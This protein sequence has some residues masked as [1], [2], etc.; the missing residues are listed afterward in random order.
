MDNKYHKLYN[1]NFTI[2]YIA[3]PLDCEVCKVWEKKGNIWK[4]FEYF[5][6]H[7]IQCQHAG[8]S[9]DFI[10]FQQRAFMCLQCY[11][12]AN[13]ELKKRSPYWKFLKI[14]L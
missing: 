11:K 6:Y 10:L 4:F 5:P 9:D 13:S 1:R 2:T 7:C 8:Y 3:C 12:K 14:E